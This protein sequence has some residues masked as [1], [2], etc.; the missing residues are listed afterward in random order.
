MLSNTSKKALN[1]AAVFMQ[2]AADAPA[3]VALEM[4]KQAQ[5]NI[6]YALEEAQ[7]QTAVMPKSDA[8]QLYEDGGKQWQRGDVL[9][10]NGTNVKATIVNTR[11]QPDGKTYYKP[12]GWPFYYPYAYFANPEAAPSKSLLEGDVC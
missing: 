10:F 11:T 3:H 1:G 2:N 7:A 12:E 9:V 6:N 4:L 8:E 5:R